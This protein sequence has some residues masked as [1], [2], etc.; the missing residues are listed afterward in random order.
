[1]D[2]RKNIEIEAWQRSR[3]F[4]LRD[5]D[6]NTSYFH[7]RT[8][9]SKTRNT[10]ISLLDSAGVERS[11]LKGLLHVVYDYYSDFFRSSRLPID[12][13]LFEHMDVR[14]SADMRDILLKP[15]CKEEVVKALREMHPTK[16]LG[17]DGFPAYFY[18]QFWDM[19]G[20]DVCNMVVRFLNCGGMPERVN[21]THVVLI[22]KVK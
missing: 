6:K 15:Y 16:S 18:H 3:P 7:Y 11:D 9:Q 10:I 4:I 13:D 22:P 21:H 1:M 19:V 12:R 14:L 2:I 8:S 20:D 17:P 5:G